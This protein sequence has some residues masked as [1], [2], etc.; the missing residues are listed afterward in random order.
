MV[1]APVKVFGFGEEDVGIAA[2]RCE[3][4]T[5]FACT[6]KHRFSDFIVNE[7]TEKG[8]V[9]YFKPENDLEKWMTVK[10]VIPP[11]LEESKEEEEKKQQDVFELTEEGQSKLKD[12]LHE[13]D[14]V[15]IIDYLKG[16][17]NGSIEKS[18]VFIF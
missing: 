13:E 4:N 14:Y 1:E 17:N 6:M 10:K 3:A 12:W 18:E 7:I 11:P 15:R 8:E 9:V 5:P 16:L 2:Y